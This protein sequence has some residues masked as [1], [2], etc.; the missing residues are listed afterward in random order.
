[1]SD[2]F[3]LSED[4]KAVYGLVAAIRRDLANGIKYKDKNG[5]AITCEKA[6]LRMIATKESYTTDDADIVDRVT[7]EQMYDE[8]TAPLRARYAEIRK[9]IEG[10]KTN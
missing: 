6:V 2:I 5:L 7:F 9:L 1:M 4:Q 3:D 8:V 10:G